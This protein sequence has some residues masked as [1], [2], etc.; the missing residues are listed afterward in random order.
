[1][2]NHRGNQIHAVRPGSTFELYKPASPAQTEAHIQLQRLADGIVAKQDTV[3]AEEHPW[4]KA[5]LIFLWGPPGAGK[6]HLV[7]A[8]VNR[9]R[10]KAPRLVKQ[11]RI[12]LSRYSFTLE[13]IASVSTYDGAPIVII[14]DIWAEYTSLN[15]LNDATDV[16]CFMGF[17]A[18][19]YDRRTFVLVTSNFPIKDGILGAVR[20][21]DKI[22]RTTSRLAE[23]LAGSGEIHL[24]GPDHRQTLAEQA[25]AGDTFSV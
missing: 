11:R 2:S 7:E 3:L 13:H 5:K 20:R 16:R 1:M 14:D 21:V 12:Y 6:T 18:S 17:V 19:I 25:G 8:V 9:V 22:G 4:P 23:L 15:R 10:E 24:D